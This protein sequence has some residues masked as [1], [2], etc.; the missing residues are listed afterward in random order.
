MTPENRAFLRAICDAPHDDLPRLVYADFLEES[1]H[2]ELV[3]RAHFI[4]AQIAMEQLTTSDLEYHAFAGVA[5]RCLDMFGD[6]WAWDLPRWFREE[7]KFTYRRGFPEVVTAVVGSLMRNGTELREATPICDLR[8]EQ[9]WISAG[10]FDLIP[11]LAGVTALRLGPG[12]SDH[13]VDL[14]EIPEDDEHADETP[15]DFNHPMLGELIR[16]R[17]LCNVAVLDLSQNQLTNDWAV[18]FV[19]ALPTAAFA[20]SLRELDLSMNFHLTDAA[21]NLFATTP[22][23]EN[24]TRLR[25]RDTGIT[26]AGETMLK[27]RFGSRVQV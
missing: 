4:R 10:S 19:S 5:E 16:C 25:I 8:L 15:G 9:E 13:V 22:A 7:C 26:R 1:E 11:Q 23:F 14:T 17:L 24:L 12:L 21:A 27:R 20:E 6:N 18:R 2:P 3:A